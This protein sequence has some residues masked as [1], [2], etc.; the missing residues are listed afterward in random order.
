MTPAV[1]VVLAAAAGVLTVALTYSW[2]DFPLRLALISG[3]A[4]GVLVF[5]TL[6]AS[7]RLGNIYR[8]R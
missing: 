3:V 4:V 8:R 5:S 7:A 1:K 6:Q 2:R